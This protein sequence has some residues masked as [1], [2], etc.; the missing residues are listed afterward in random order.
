MAVAVAA[1]ADDVATSAIVIATSTITV[2]A[3]DIAVAILDNILLRSQNRVACFHLEKEAFP[4]QNWIDLVAK[5]AGGGQDAPAFIRRQSWPRGKE[6]ICPSKISCDSSPRGKEIIR[7][8]NRR[9]LFLKKWIL[10]LLRLYFQLWPLI[11]LSKGPAKGPNDQLSGWWGHFQGQSLCI[12]KRS[13]NIVNWSRSP[14][15][16]AF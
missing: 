9:T 10:D 3:Y 14:M 15:K 16:K 11:C 13:C 2:A 5:V 7:S 4:P 12:S 1:S 6:F 8:K